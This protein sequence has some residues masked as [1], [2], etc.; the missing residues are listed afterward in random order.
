M[1][2]KAIF[3]ISIVL[4]VAGVSY[5]GFTAYKFFTRDTSN[6]ANEQTKQENTQSGSVEL[7]SSSNQEIITEN[8]PIGQQV[9]ISAGLKNSS[10]DKVSTNFEGR[11]YSVNELFTFPNI[12]TDLPVDSKP[13]EVSLESGASDNFSYDSAPASCGSYYMALADKDYWNKGRG[14]VTYGYFTVS[15]DGVVTDTEQGNN[16]TNTG[17]TGTTAK[18]IADQKQ[19][20]TVAGTSTTKGGLDST[21]Q[22]GL[23]STSKGGQPVSQLPKSGPSETAMAFGVLS[24][25]SAFAY[26]LKKIRA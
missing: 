23:D 2:D 3:I 16:V 24:I 15:C 21:N 14:T 18:E 12:D 7:T 19:A 25:L 20:G 5:L 17:S 13:V 8:A 1:K 26:R 11:T 4:V 6:T 10:D 9:T 22:G